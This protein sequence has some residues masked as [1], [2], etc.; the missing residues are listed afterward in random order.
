HLVAF[1][2]PTGASLAEDALREAL[3]ARLPEYM[4]PSRFV[5]L[6]GLPRT[7]NGKVD[8]RALSRLDLTG[9]AA[10]RPFVAP[11]DR[12]ELQVARIWE[13]LLGTGPIGV[14]DSFFA[15]GG[16]SLLAVSLA[17]RIREAFGREIP[18]A[19]LFQ[20]S[21]V[22][23]L[24][25][26]LRRE[27]IDASTPL[28]KIQTGGAQTPVFLVHPV[29]GG[30]LCYAD[31]ARHLGPRVPVYGLE[32]PALNGG[33]ESL[34]TIEA[35]AERYLAEVR[36]V[37]PE[38]PFRLAGWSLGG[39]VAFEMARRLEAEGQT[40]HLGL[41]DT[42]PPGEY[43][44]ASDA[45]LLLGFARDLAAMLGQGIPEPVAEEIRQ[46]DVETGL[47]R[48]FS[49]AQEA[50]LLPP[51]L[52]LARIRRLFD[53]FRANYQAAHL[54]QGGTYQGP[55]L[56]I[57]ADHTRTQEPHREAVWRQQVAGLETR[58]LEGNHYDLV[59][60]PLSSEVA[61]LLNA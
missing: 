12:V 52:D 40:V 58:I 22:E 27:A 39:L 26:L 33:G 4:V 20:A 21:T 47:A 61:A 14:H 34:S 42:T 41:L 15:L 37:Q 50:G 2:V 7:P 1:L 38:G 54:Y 56:F 46:S 9:P 55:A 18:V 19:T 53:L 10:G 3:G 32:S 16:H 60:S 43:G 44:P 24:A 45:D 36:R 30:V 59:R 13:E 5:A 29:G 11:R 23:R 25:G 35:M 49:L 6:G 8:R 51:G 17:V 31:L 48:L 57:E 28:V